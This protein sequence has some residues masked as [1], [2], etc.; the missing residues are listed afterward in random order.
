M[1]GTVFCAQL[2]VFPSVHTLEF[3]F[4]SINGRERASSIFMKTEAWTLFS[5]SFA[6]RGEWNSG[7]IRNSWENSKSPNCSLKDD[8]NNS[9]WLVLTVPLQW[10]IGRKVDR[11]FSEHRVSFLGV[12]KESTDWPPKVINTRGS[13]GIIRMG[14]CV[15]TPRH[16]RS[17]LSWESDPWGLH[18]RG[19]SLLQYGPLQ[20]RHGAGGSL[21][22]WGHSCLRCPFF[23]Q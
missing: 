10:W 12:Q 11:G 18:L 1:T 21:D 9:L 7:K 8:W 14:A 6:R 23:P 5:I 16:L 20:T 2:I 17:W 4:C 3:T 13:S 22:A 19:Q 15:G